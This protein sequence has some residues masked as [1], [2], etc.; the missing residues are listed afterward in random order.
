MKQI[1]LESHNIRNPYF[2]FGQF[3]MHLIEALGK[4]DHD[5][6]ELVVYGNNIDNLKKTYGT[7]FSYRKYSPLSRY[8]M[9]S[10]RKKYDLWHSLNQNTKVE[11]FHD[12]PYLLT[13]H[14]ITYIKDK[15]NYKNKEV[16]QRFQ[17]KLNRSTAIT[18]ISHYAKNSTHKFFEVP[19]VPEYVIYNGNPIKEVYLPHGFQPLVS[20]KK[21][22]L[23]SIGEFTAR[24][25]FKS[26]LHMLSL[27]PEYNLILAGKNS[28]P[29]GDEIRKLI[30]EKE[31]KNRV[32]LVGKISEEEKKYYYKN[33]TAFVF[34][35][36]REGFGLPIVEAM[37]FGKPIFTSKNTSLPEIGGDL[38]FYWTSYEKEHM[39]EVFEKGIKKFENNAFSYREKLI[40]RAESFDWDKAAKQYLEIYK[41]LL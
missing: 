12:I 15:K 35:S 34:P 28:T 38:A 24:K 1:F 9:L 11:P 21:P 32:F 19:N 18:Y 37:R 25:N 7:K 6:L 27:L 3:N 14:N 29:N 36:L 30:T 5:E 17:Q 33:C 26:L 40:L 31:L 16:H 41:S 22:F 8:R 10:I 20:I 39:V 2:G 4:L 23:F 13:V